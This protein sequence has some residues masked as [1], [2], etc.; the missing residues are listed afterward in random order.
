M[1]SLEG[2]LAN[3]PGYGGYLA[4][5]Q[6]NEQGGMQ[7]LQQ[8]ASV[9]G[10]LANLAAQQQKQALRKSLAESGGDLQKA[11]QAAVMTG[12][13]EGAARLAQVQ[14]AQSKAQEEQVKR[15]FFSP[16]NR[17][18]FM[19]PGTPTPPMT[20]VDDN[21]N[22]NPGVE[23]A[24][25]FDFPRFLQAGAERGVVNPETY[26]NHMAQRELAASTAA[27]AQQ[28]RRDA[29]E[30]RL[31]D[32]GTRSQDRAASREQQAELA[33][34]A[35]QTRRELA[36]LIAGG[37]DTPHPVV[38]VN[39]NGQQVVNFARPSQGSQTFDS[40]PVGAATADVRKSTQQEQFIGRQYNAAAKPSREI[41]GAAETYRAVRQTGD[42][43]QA[44]SF[45]AEVLQ[46]AIRSGN[47]RFK[48]EADK[49]L[50]G[51]YRGG[52]IDERLI[53]FASQLATG[54]PTQKT[55]NDLDKLMDAVE[56]SAMQQIANQARFFGSQLRS[57]QSLINSL[58]KPFV[59]GTHVI[60]PKGDYRR[61]PTPEAAAAAA[62]KWLEEN[63]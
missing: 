7:D 40:R 60:T 56:G 1:A 50:G 28:A 52:S 25:K 45:A 49:V 27:A 34:M 2:V 46:R 59:Q 23:T 14:S 57:N 9:Q 33:K 55:M 51:G 43:P 22:V 11:M 36:A 32:I 53:N 42:T 29:L 24:P 15:E 26:A 16:Q 39:A 35:D 19:A 62:E 30:T 58:G 10:V 38:G 5:R 13:F 48:A 31:Y 54:T 12:D 3:I 63:Q 18:Q 61:F 17:A 6:M 4:Q 20:P 21:G 47:A 37:R 44:A 41:L 8:F